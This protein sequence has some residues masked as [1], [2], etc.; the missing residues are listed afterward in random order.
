M[1]TILLVE[2]EE[3]IR[4]VIVDLL[5]YE[6]SYRTLVAIDAAQAL[7][8]ATRTTFDLLVTNYRLPGTMNGIELYDCLHQI[9]GLEQVP[10]MLVSATLPEEDLT[11]RKIMGIHKPFDLDD[12]LAHIQALFG[13]RSDHRYGA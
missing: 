4:T 13:E 1:K 8:I 7:E 3:D 2:D 10:A 11:T 6:T 12:L 5:S 9:P